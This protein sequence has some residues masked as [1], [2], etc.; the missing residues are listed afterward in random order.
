MT[1]DKNTLARTIADVLYKKETITMEEKLARVGLS[2]EQVLDHMKMGSEL[3]V[4][5]IGGADEQE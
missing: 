1:I 2:M 3:N 4:K 5:K